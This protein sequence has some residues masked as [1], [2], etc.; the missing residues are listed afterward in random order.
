METVTSVV[1]HLTTWERGLVQGT[2]PRCLY[3]GLVQESFREDTGNIII[4]MLTL[5]ILWFVQ[6]CKVLSHE[7]TLLTHSVA[8]TVFKFVNS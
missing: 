1:V 5:H 2:E 3:K 8:V 7:A 4:S 6:G